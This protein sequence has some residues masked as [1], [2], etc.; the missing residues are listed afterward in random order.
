MKILKIKQQ[1][2]ENKEKTKLKD[3]DYILKNVK[4]YIEFLYGKE[5]LVDKSSEQ[6]AKEYNFSPEFKRDLTNICN[7]EYV[8]GLSDE[9]LQALVASL[10]KDFCGLFGITKVPNISVEYIKNRRK[11]IKQDLQACLEENGNVFVY[12]LSQKARQTGERINFFNFEI[13]N[14]V[15]HELMHIVVHDKLLQGI[16]QCVYKKNDQYQIN[17]K[18]FLKLDKITQYILWQ[19]LTECVILSEKKNLL[20]KLTQCVDMHIKKHGMWL[21]RYGFEEI[22]IR[23]NTMLLI[24]ELSKKK[25]I[26]QSEKQGLMHYINYTLFEDAYYGTNTFE[27]YNNMVRELFT[28]KLEFSNGYGYKVKIIKDLLALKEDVAQ[29]SS[30]YCASY[31]AEA[32]RSL[33]KEKNALKKQYN[34]LVESNG[35]NLPLIEDKVGNYEVLKYLY[36]VYMLTEQKQSASQ[37]RKENLK[38]GDIA[39]CITSIYHN[40]LVKKQCKVK[41]ARQTKEQ[42]ACK[43]Q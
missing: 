17:T 8:Y 34:S 15:I 21:Y 40:S 32:T 33:Q 2:Q 9:E 23:A 25:F 36:A 28:E 24:Q 5:G 43:K 41:K 35:V 18:A 7:A 19:K 29:P 27:V 13:L 1:N 11:F 30:E 16:K 37:C 6:N 14:S 10:T 42:N 31:I 22:Y 26:P 38:Y 4:E 12:S 3:E 20:K 39:N